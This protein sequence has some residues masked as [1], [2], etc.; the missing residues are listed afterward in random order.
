[1]IRVIDPSLNRDAIGALVAVEA[2]GRTYSREAQPSSS[3]LSSHDVRI[4]FGLGGAERFTRIIVT[5]PSGDKEEFPAGDADRQIMLRR[6]TGR[7]AK[8][9]R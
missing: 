1:M 9:D 8:V 4:H 3:Y 7:T 2:G 5:W 6:G